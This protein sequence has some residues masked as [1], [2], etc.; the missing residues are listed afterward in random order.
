L[1]PGTRPKSDTA[2]ALVKARS[3][4]AA[5]NSRMTGGWARERLL[6]TDVATKSRPVRVAAEPA[7]TAK[8]SR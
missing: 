4:A 2:K 8:S 6:V 3:E 5:L 1:V 7:M